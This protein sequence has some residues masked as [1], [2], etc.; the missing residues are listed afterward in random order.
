MILTP[1]Q[2][3]VRFDA[4]GFMPGSIVQV[5]S[6]GP[7][8]EGDSVLRPDRWYDATYTASESCEVSEKVTIVPSSFGRYGVYLAGDRYGG[9]PTL[10]MFQLTN[11]SARL[12]A[13]NVNPTSNTLTQS[14]PEAPTSLVAR[15][16]DRA[17]IRLQWV[18][19]ARTEQSYRIEVNSGRD[20]TH[21]VPGNSTT[22][23]AGGLRPD[24]EYCFTVKAI[25]AHGPSEGVEVCAQTAR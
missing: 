3:G 18:D 17:S 19:N 16:V 14:A 1:A 7:V 25:N 12:S 22:Y 2:D 6:L 11:M 21:A 9:G 20:G 15:P 13:P 4:R 5:W 24:T 8:R 10:T 23:T